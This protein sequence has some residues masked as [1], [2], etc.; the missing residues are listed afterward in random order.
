[1]SDYQSPFIAVETTGPLEEDDAL[2]LHE[3][4]FGNLVNVIQ[5][6]I[7]D[8]ND[9]YRKQI[10]D[11][12]FSAI[13]FCE[14]ETFYFNENRDIVFNTVDGQ[15]EYDE[16]DN[17]NIVT[18]VQI[19]R[20]FVI[21]N[22]MVSELIRKAPMNMELLMESPVLGIPNSYSYFN[23]KLFLYPVPN[24]NYL[25]RLILSPRR[26]ENISDIKEPHPWFEDGFDLIKARAKYELF[27]NI[28][29]EPDRAQ[30]AMN[31]FNEHLQ[32]IRYETSKRSNATRIVSTDF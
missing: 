21:N 24:N 1:M 6:E 20:A 10:Q 22:D 30:D 23:K 11:S 7:D 8:Q 31:D 27:K 5:D 3:P 13:R 17:P 26:F 25:I 32:S 15:R 14:R 18:S 12:I 9:E 29:R 2:F 19:S 28:L 16:D 4:T